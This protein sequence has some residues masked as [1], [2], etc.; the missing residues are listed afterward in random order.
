MAHHRKLVAAAAALNSAIFVVEAAAGFVAESLSL[1]MDSVHNLSDEMALVLLYLAFILPHGISRHLLRSANLFNS[2]GL[3]LVSALLL[4]Q[5]VERILHP[6]PV[7]GSVAIVVGLAAA[8]ANWGV[9][10][11]LLKPSRNNAAIRL[12]Y[13]HNIGDCYVSLAPVAA[14]LLVTLTGYS[15][16]DPLIAGGIAVWIIISTVREVFASSDELIWPEKIVCGHS[17][18][19]QTNT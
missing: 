18:E 11:L 4:W 13:I 14:G 16:F 2:V 15:I 9:A 7:L 3:V 5:A 12:A 1:V 17:D 19:Q 8:V 10:R 6:A